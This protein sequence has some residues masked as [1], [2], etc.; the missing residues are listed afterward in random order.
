MNENLQ[1]TVSVVAN[2]PPE[3]PRVVYV[4]QTRRRDT[5]G[6]GRGSILYNDPA[7]ARNSLAIWNEGATEARL[8]RIELPEWEVPRA[9]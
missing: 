1:A 8:L 9:D 3:N 7:E 6:L 5:G 4:V 2:P